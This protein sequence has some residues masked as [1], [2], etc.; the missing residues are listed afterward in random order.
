[1]KKTIFVLALIILN[2]SLCFA[3]ENNDYEPTIV[4]IQINHDLLTPILDCT[5]QVDSIPLALEPV[6]I[7]FHDQTYLKAHNINIYELPYSWT[8][9]CYDWKRLWIN[10]ATLTGAFV[11]SLAVLECL[12]EDATS[13]N[14]AEIQDVPLFKRWKDNVIQKGL[15]FDKDKWIF[16]YVLHPYAGA[17]YFMGARNCGFNFWQSLLYSALI[18]TVGWE[19]GIEAF[20]EPPSIQDILITPIVGSLIGE[21]FYKIK[22]KIVENGYTLAGSKVLGNVVAFFVDPLNEFLGLFY[23]SPSRAA[24]KLYEKKIDVSSSFIVNTS[25]GPCPG[26]AINC[27][28]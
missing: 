21:G 3:S 2:F 19:F 6:E 10:T 5:V 8:G 17:A 20:M 25:S 24:A 27:V 11:G 13:W 14:R 7:N 16:N 18:S 12:P 28:F 15:S 26:I 1:M 9:K 4:K 23:G 22:R